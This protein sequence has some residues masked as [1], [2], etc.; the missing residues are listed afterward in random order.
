M[1]EYAQDPAI[2]NQIKAIK[3]DKIEIKIDYNQAGKPVKVMDD[4]GATIA[5][6][7]DESG[8]INKLKESQDT[9]AT[10][11]KEIK[12]YFLKYYQIIKLV[13]GCECMR[14]I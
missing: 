13:T 6:E 11:A 5:V 12:E 8:N 14:S 4:D 2:A 9:D 10:R 3:S 1:V 7:Y